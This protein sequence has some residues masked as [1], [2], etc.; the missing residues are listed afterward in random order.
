M[1][2]THP[3]LDGPLLGA[4]SFYGA[5]QCK[6]EQCGAIFTDLCHA[7]PRK[8]PSHAHELPFFELILDG[9]YGERYGRQDRQ[10]RP[11]TALFRPRGVPHQDEI[12]PR[13]V[14]LFEIELRPRWRKLLEDCSAHLEHGR[15]DCAGGELMWLC[16]RLYRK[17]HE[18][19]AD[20][21]E[22]ESLLSELLACVARMP[23]E[24]MPV[25]P[26][27]LSSV[28]EKL[29]AD[30]A[31]TI[32]LDELSREAGV[33]P[34]HLSRVF[35]KSKGQGIGDYVHRLRIRAACEQM[36]ALE[37]PIAEI[38]LATGFADQSHFTRSFR[39]VTGMTPAVF[40]GQLLNRR[41][42]HNR[43]QPRSDNIQASSPRLNLSSGA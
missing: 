36:R 26:A 9:Q 41:K 43:Q 19:G 14:S 29:N 24:R 12:G 1:G 18:T 28:V 5:I 8:L 32:T 23:S 42:S 38:G 35:R 7:S 25:W 17:L 3:G 16:L 40:R 27:W 15:E 21:L 31:R 6:H 11:F 2:E 10:F 34:V 39:R 4:G 22:V 13:G 20:A 33:H 30:F 37:T